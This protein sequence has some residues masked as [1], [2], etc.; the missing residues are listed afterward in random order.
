M[1]DNEEEAAISLLERIKDSQSNAG[2]YQ[3]LMQGVLLRIQAEVL[4]KTN[5]I[6]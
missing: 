1:N 2:E 4:K 3:A 5:N 6:E